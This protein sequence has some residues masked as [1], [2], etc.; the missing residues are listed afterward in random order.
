MKPVTPRGPSATRNLALHWDYPVHAEEP[1][2][3][4]AD[5]DTVAKQVRRALARAEAVASIA[6][7][8]PRPLLV[9]RECLV[10]NGTDD[11][12]LKPGA[13]NEKTFLLA[14]W[15]HC[16]K[17]PP[18]VMQEDH[19]Y[20][21]L[22]VQEQP[23]HLFVLSR[24]GEEHLPLESQT[25]RVELWTSMSRM[26]EREYGQSP[27]ALMKKVGKLLDKMDV[28]DHRAGDLERR[29]DD[30]IEEEGPES[31]KTKKV[32][33]ELRELQEERKALDEQFLEQTRLELRK[34]EAAK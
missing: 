29:L 5:G 18:D 23:E 9:L 10:C 16:V 13:D 27:D 26:V 15:F 19:P 30:L 20:R 12:L 28:V 2:A 32:R 4:A 31:R 17:L 33:E 22:F 6:G 14:R 8:D 34:P 11:A 25:S 7:D 1:K 3:A 21:A 24:D